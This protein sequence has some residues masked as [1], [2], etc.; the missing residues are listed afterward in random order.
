MSILAFAALQSFN[1]RLRAK[2]GTALQPVRVHPEFAYVG[3]GLCAT[4][5][6]VRAKACTLKVAKLAN[7]TTASGE[8]DEV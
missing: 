4:G 7:G 8:G 5:L 6:P 2:H 3:V 1:A